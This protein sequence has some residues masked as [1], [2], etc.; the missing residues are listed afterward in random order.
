MAPLSRAT[1]IR[2]LRSLD[3]ERFVEFVASLW[4]ASG[5]TVRR[6]NRRLRIHYRGRTRTFSVVRRSWWQ[7][8]VPTIEPPESDID[9]I[10]TDT[11]ERLSGVSPE[12]RVIDPMELHE[13]LLYGLD[14][15]RAETI[16]QRFFD[17]SLEESTPTGD[18]GRIERKEVVV[19]VGVILGV[20]AL[21]G[22]VVVVETGGL[23]GPGQYQ[24]GGSSYEPAVIDLP[25]TQ[26]WPGDENESAVPEDTAQCFEPS[27]DELPY[28]EMRPN[29]DGT[30]RT[31]TQPSKTDDTPANDG[32][33]E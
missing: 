5:A 17:R 6:E 20:L 4:R 26:M 11:P 28:T 33:T 25:Y 27:V 2:Q 9:G 12:T 29:H 10:I 31:A 19:L 18:G 24:N 16:T 14:R 8:H 7:D 23:S 15:K 21:A 1:F 13:R 3:D 32:C 30:T 22:S